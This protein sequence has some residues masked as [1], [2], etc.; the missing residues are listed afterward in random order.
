MASVRDIPAP[1][2]AQVDTAA[3]AMLVRS[4]VPVVVVDA[5]TGDYD[6]G[7]RIPGARNLGS[8]ASEN[9]ARRVIGSKDALIVTYCT[10]LQCPA[11]TRLYHRLKELGYENVL[12]YHDGIAGWLA[13]GFP[14]EE[15]KPSE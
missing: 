2:E 5:R 11:S 1:A 14:I 13:A 15:R 9:D 6:D 12:E 10:S 7:T 3:L 8:G 4:G